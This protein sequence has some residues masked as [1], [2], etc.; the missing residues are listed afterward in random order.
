V[1]IRAA[2]E[3]AKAAIAAMQYRYC[4]GRNALPVL[5]GLDNIIRA[6]FKSN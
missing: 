1:T 4:E 6:H 3:Y 2:Q 5:E